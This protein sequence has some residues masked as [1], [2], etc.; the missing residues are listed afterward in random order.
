[1]QT[2]PSMLGLPVDNSFVDDAYRHQMK[3]A[4]EYVIHGIS[5]Q[6]YFTWFTRFRSIPFDD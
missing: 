3:H 1:M 4:C 5:S 2:T 6:Q